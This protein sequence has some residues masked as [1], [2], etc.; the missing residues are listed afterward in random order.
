MLFYMKNQNLQNTHILYK[1]IKFYKTID[2]LLNKFSIMIEKIYRNKIL[3][4][5]KCIKKDFLITCLEYIFIATIIIVVNTQLS[6]SLIPFQSPSTK[7]SKQKFN[8]I[9]LNL[10]N[11]GTP[12][13]IDIKPTTGFTADNY[14]RTRDNSGFIFND[15]IFDVG[16]DFY[17]NGTLIINVGSG[18][19][20][21][22]NKDSC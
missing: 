5:L 22:K 3:N 9:I 11:G 2:D 14:I 16:R 18:C 21:Y 19:Q 7:T 17:L 15:E 8:D 13:P 12:G 10:G 6:K 1:L 20:H 4:S